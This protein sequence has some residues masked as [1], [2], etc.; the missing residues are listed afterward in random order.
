MKIEVQPK[1][2]ERPTTLRDR[3][4]RRVTFARGQLSN[5]LS[6]VSVVSLFGGRSEDNEGHESGAAGSLLLA[7]VA[8]I[9]AMLIQLGILRSREHLADETGARISGDPGALASALGS[10]FRSA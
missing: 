9:A 8:P 1:E 2:T 4:R 7:F 3:V 6:G 5:R 10:Q